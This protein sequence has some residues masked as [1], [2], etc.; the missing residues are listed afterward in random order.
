MQTDL[1]KAVEEKNA[2]V[3]K[4]LT[5]QA[6]KEQDEK[7]QAYENSLGRIV[8]YEKV[9]ELKY[10]IRFVQVFSMKVMDGCIR[11]DK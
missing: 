9:R 11:S 6:Q 2:A 3:N 1:T 4:I 5:E 10:K 8:K 7:S